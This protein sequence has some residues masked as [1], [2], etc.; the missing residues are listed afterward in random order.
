[1][2]F[3][4]LIQ[5]GAEEKHGVAVAYETADKAVQLLRERVDIGRVEF[6]RAAQLF[7]DVK[8]FVQAAKCLRNAREYGLA[9]MLWEKMGQVRS[10]LSSFCRFVRSWGDLFQVALLIFFCRDSFSVFVVFV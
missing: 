4:F 10:F 7:L 8:H 1:M 6:V 3:S 5:A 2:S 9:A